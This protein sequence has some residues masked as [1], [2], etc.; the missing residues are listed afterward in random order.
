MAKADLFAN[1]AAS[2]PLSEVC[3]R[4]EGEMGEDFPPLTTQSHAI[5]GCM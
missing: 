3:S 2:M 1:I 5:R 4:S